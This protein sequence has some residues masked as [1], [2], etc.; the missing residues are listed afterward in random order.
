M[1]VIGINEVKRR[2]AYEYFLI[3][4]AEQNPLP[5]VTRDGFL[6]Y[7]QYLLSNLFLITS[8]YELPARERRLR[9]LHPACNLG[10]LS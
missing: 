2:C 4:W 5:H 1:L 8:S 6:Y 10:E 7:L 9:R 3:C